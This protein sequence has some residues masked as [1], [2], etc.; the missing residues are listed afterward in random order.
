MMERAKEEKKQTAPGDG[1]IENLQRSKVWCNPAAILWQF[2]LMPLLLMC[3]GMDFLDERGERRRWYKCYGWQSDN[4]SDREQIKDGL[5]LQ[6]IKH[7]GWQAQ[8]LLHTHGLLSWFLQSSCVY[9]FQNL[10]CMLFF[11]FFFAKSPEMKGR[12]QVQW[13]PLKGDFNP[14]F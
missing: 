3:C 4:F 8:A 7:P 13:T 5:T 11:F 10:K 14:T 2:P 1:W 6:S 9:I 12:R